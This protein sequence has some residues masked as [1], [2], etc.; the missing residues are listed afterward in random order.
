MTAPN[1]SHLTPDNIVAFI[2]DIFQRRGADSYLGENVS[3][4]EHML[5]CALQAEEEGVSDALIAAALLHDIGHY[6]GE[7]PEDAL[8]KG[9]NNHHDA[10]GAVVL[11]PFFPA[12]VTACVRGHV[13]AKRY[14]CTTDPAY[15]ERLSA[16]SVHTLNLQGGP[17]S[18]EEV[19]S[20][21]SARYLDEII[22]VRIW[23]EGS[24]V[25]GRPTPTFEHYAPILQ[26]VVD[27]HSAA[28]L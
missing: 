28:N 27:S 21:Q 10:A 5:Q 23:D 14:L 26:R 25:A 22:R 17:M 11:T 1:F 8:E 12:L 18:S 13:S 19:E 6:T 16:A 24:K 2:G 7:F 3:M 4:S 20:F 9:I 15:F